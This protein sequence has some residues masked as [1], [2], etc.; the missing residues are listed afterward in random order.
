M[1]KK[2][3]QPSKKGLPAGYT[4]SISEA[5]HYFKKWQT[6]PLYVDEDLALSV[7]F[8]GSNSYYRLNDSL[9]KILVKVATLNDFYSTQ[10][11]RI[12]DLALKIASIPD[13]DNR[14]VKGDISLVNDIRR[15]SYTN[16]SGDTHVRDDYSFATKF[17]SAHNPA[18]FPIYDKYV[19]LVLCDLKKQYPNVFTFPNKDSLRDYAVFKQALD[20]LKNHWNSLS[21]LDYKELDRYLWLLGKNY[22]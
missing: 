20:D 5:Q 6:M 1:A 3:N 16:M 2:L 9:D 17:C 21:G 8:R 7:L 22:F 12:Y 14:L 11:R 13:L 18:L 10:I 4:P 19:M 15:N